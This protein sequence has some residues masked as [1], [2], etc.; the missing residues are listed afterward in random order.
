MKKI[1]KSIQLLL[2]VLLFCVHAT[3]VAQTLNAPTLQFGD[4]AC[5]VTGA[6]NFFIDITFSGQVFNDDNE[7]IIELSDANSI[8]PDPAINLGTLRSTT[9]NNYNTRYNIV[10]V[11]ITLPTGT[12]GKTYQIRIRTTSPVMSSV[13]SSFEAYHDMV[14]LSELG[15]NND[16][17]FAICNGESKE[18]SL[19]T[20]VV[21][22]YLWYK[23]GSPDTLVGTTQDPKFTITQPG[24]YY[25]VIDYGLCGGPKSRYINAIGIS[26]ADAQIA[27]AS[28]IEIC[29]DEAHTFEASSNNSAYTYEWYKDD[30]L[31]QSSGSNTYTT[32]TADQF[33]IYHLVVKLG[34]CEVKSSDVELKQKEAPS[35]TI[36]EEVPLISVILPGE[37]KD[38]EISVSGVTNYTVKW[39]RNNILLANQNDLILQN[40]N[41]PGIYVATVIDTDAS[42]GSCEASLSS[43]PIVLLAPV[44]FET[45]IRADN[46]EECTSEAT[47]LK[48][49]GIE[50]V[51]TDGNKYDLTNDQLNA[52]PALITYQWKNS[53]GAITGATN[54]EHAVNSY[55]ESSIY[56]LNVK[57]SFTNSDSNL[58]DV[59]LIKTP[60]V[61]ST[62]VSNSLCSG[63][64]ITY[65]IDE[66]LMGYTYEWFKDADT[67]PIAANVKD[68]IVTEIGEYTL[69]VTGYGCEKNVETIVVVPFDDSAIVVSPSEI[70]VLILGQT[71]T[72]TA[73]GAESYVWYEGT[74]V[75]GTGTI[76]STNET[77][78]A[79]A[80]GFYTVVATVGGCTVPKTIEVV[81]Q[82]D[83]VI[84]PNIVTPN[85][86]GINDT[87]QLSNKYSFKPS[88]NI[89]LYNSNGKEILNVTDYKNDWPTESL[90]NQK[91][92]YYKIIKDD[93]LIKAGTISVLD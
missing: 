77:F 63:S 25:A 5:D 68:F 85:E 45:V 38:L 56:S 16:E 27:G 12:F 52:T 84:V 6:T 41:Q 92:F 39:E 75:S 11:P 43:Q 13:S 51:A 36:S 73:S 81:E 58:L 90:G 14:G 69:K 65:T 64:D 9:T 4:S 28:T 66:L 15:I 88:V 40:I 42:S 57:A 76:L 46:Y 54:N 60:E 83:Q 55:L 91:V 53:S 31:K 86:D 24:T 48:I 74:D 32:P 37:E 1:A 87:W 22:Q 93:A 47:V 26:N 71:V 33:G 10:N 2:G 23:V 61:T 80:L 30:E 44:S 59:K 21:G 49:V 34:D 78:D 20:D 82:D 72:I 29:G 17:D 50:A 67:T 7:F 18:V 8:F 62:S 35:F 19:T 89:L 79:T 3:S 70:V